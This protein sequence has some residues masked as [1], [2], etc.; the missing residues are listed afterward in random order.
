MLA[1]R[2]VVATGAEGVQDLLGA[3]GG[4]ILS[5]ENDPPT[6]SSALQR[7]ERDAALRAR[8]GTM[9]RRLAEDQH[10][11]P[12]VAERLEKLILGVRRDSRE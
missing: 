8:D 11:A 2:P 12:L 10:S 5:P 6:L 9:A 3:G 1:E 7:Y 4:V